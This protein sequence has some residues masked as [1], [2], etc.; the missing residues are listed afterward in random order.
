MG[1]KFVGTYL[2]PN[3]PN[4]TR[5]MLAKSPTEVLVYGFDAGAVGLENVACHGAND[6]PW[7]PLNGK[8]VN[9]NIVIDFTPKGGPPDLTGNLDPTTKRLNWTGHGADGNYWPMVQAFLMI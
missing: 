4:C 6:K 2:D 7:G 1:N 5:T 9:G 3:H 8:V